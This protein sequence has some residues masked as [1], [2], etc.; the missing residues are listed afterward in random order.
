LA[1]RVTFS[2]SVLNQEAAAYFSGAAKVFSINSG[3]P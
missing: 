1:G 2:K 3:V